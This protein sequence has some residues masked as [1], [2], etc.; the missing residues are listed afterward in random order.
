MSVMALPHGPCYPREF[1]PLCLHRYV[2]ERT[3]L[4][5]SAL[6][7]TL[8]HAV[9]TTIHSFCLMMCGNVR[10]DR[11]SW[12][13]IPRLLPPWLLELSPTQTKVTPEEE[14]SIKKLPPL[15]WS[16]GMSG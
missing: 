7:M 14:T 10:A 6:V 15:A 4:C 2:C 12:E 16:E 3:Q 5:L 13:E 8:Q 1:T 11:L 9:S